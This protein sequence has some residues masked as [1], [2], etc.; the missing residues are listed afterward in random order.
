MKKEEKIFCQ[1]RKMKTG[2]KNVT[3]V[4]SIAYRLEKHVY[5]KESIT[6]A[7]DHP[8]GIKIAFLK[9]DGYYGRNKNETDKK[10]AGAV[11]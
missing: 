9:V 7:D 4:V 1:K 6:T 2:K 5:F 3:V 10:S 8:F 11:L